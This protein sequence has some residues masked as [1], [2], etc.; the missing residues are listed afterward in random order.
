[1]R[2]AFRTGTRLLIDELGAALLADITIT[3]FTWHFNYLLGLIVFGLSWSSA[4]AKRRANSSFPLKTFR[5]AL[6]ALAS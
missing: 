1:M 3:D 6:D 2:H 4:A 5:Y